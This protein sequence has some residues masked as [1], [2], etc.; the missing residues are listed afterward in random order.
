MG[1]NV[2]TLVKILKHISLSKDEVESQSGDKHSDGYLV[3]SGK[4]QPSRMLGKSERIQ[5]HMVR[6]DEVFIAWKAL[7][8][9]TKRKFTATAIKPIEVL[10]I[11]FL[12]PLK[13]SEK[14]TCTCSTVDNS[15]WI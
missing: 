3:K 6:E 15:G 4:N 12:Y 11:S 10:I 7:L 13:K 1:Q 5:F 8:Q 9:N 2:T 14:Q